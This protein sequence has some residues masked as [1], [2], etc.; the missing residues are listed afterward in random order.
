MITSGVRLK[1]GREKSVLNGHPWIFSGGIQSELG[2]PQ[3]GDVVAVESDRGE[4][5]GV[6]F[7]NPK[8]QIRVR[9]IAGG[10]GDI[11]RAFWM[12]RLDTCYRRRATLLKTTNAVRIVHGESDGIPGLVI[13]QLGSVVVVQ[14][15]SAGI[16][17]LVDIIKDWIVLT[18]KPSA[19]IERSESPSLKAEGLYRPQSVWWG[20]TDG[21]VE[22]QEGKLRFWVDPVH[23]QKTGFFIDQR[24]NRKRVMDLAAKSVMNL[25]SF[26]GGFTVAA[27]MHNASTISVD[28][29]A[30]ATELVTQNLHLN[31]LSSTA[32]HE[33]TADVFEY[34]RES[35]EMAD[36]VIVDPPALVKRH[37]DVTKGARAYKDVNRLGFKRVNS[38]GYMLSCSCSQFVDWH[39]FR[40]ILF[41]A[42][43]E[44]GRAVQIIG[45]FTQ[46]EDHPV[47]LYFPEGEYLKTFLL[48]VF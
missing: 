33:I 6:G 5:I 32:H 4:W 19:I 22:I 30:T 24:D 8:S 27:A 3:S 17:P 18:L 25:F 31:G 47:N 23:G 13:D 42:G 21:P 1:P 40:Q 11:C 9:L 28:S 20:S 12:D 16:E 10:D 45:Q 7:F 14:V 35:T 2:N 26:S 15:S 39:L 41:A 34:L 36:L 38:G 48:R 46:P 43:V 44:S 37:A 29:S